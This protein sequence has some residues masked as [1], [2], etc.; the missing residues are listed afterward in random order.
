MLGQLVKGL[1]VSKIFLLLLLL[2]LHL[3]LHLLL[4]LIP[5]LNCKSMFEEI[6]IKRFSIFFFFP[7]EA[8]WCLQWWK[9]LFS[10]HTTF[11]WGQPN[12]TCKLSQQKD[13]QTIKFLLLL[14]HQVTL[15]ESSS[16]KP[17][18]KKVLWTAIP[19]LRDQ[20]FALNNSKPNIYDGLWSSRFIREGAEGED[21][22]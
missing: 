3:F 2:H 5:R 22:A 6:K 4:R 11:I 16:Q 17:E 10:I 14:W 1:L 13:Q 21:L 19:A 7:R 8:R 9:C 20:R 18:I 12:L 15:S